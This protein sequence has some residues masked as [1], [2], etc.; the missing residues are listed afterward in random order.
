MLNKAWHLKNKM[1]KNPTLKD[2][3]SWH[4]DHLVNCTCRDSRP[5]IKKLKEEMKKKKGAKSSI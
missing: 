5:M 4:E 3:I 2:R 1:P